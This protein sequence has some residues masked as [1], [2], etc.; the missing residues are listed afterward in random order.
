VLKTYLI[1]SLKNTDRILPRSH[2]LFSSERGKEDIVVREELAIMSA[3]YIKKRQSQHSK[4]K[5]Y[6]IYR[7]EE[8]TDVPLRARP[9]P[10]KFATFWKGAGIAR[11][12]KRVAAKREGGNWEVP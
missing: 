9:L 5:G 2:I 10:W 11:G 12:K 8:G 4:R 1:L 6:L 3:S 7:R